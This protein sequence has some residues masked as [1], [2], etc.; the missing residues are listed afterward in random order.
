MV[1]SK[2][3]PR[4]VQY[5]NGQDANVSKFYDDLHTRYV[6]EVLEEIKVILSLL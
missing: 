5:T 6:C 1:D 2:R 4:L 3:C